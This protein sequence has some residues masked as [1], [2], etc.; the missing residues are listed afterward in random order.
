MGSLR[1]FWLALAVTPLIA[2]GEVE[3]PPVCAECYKIDAGA[4]DG[5]LV[6]GGTPGFPTSGVGTVGQCDGFGSPMVQID[7]A[8]G[9]YCIDQ[10]EAT[11]G[12]YDT[13]RAVARNARLPA[14]CDGNA[15]D[16][17][18]SPVNVD[19]ARPVY[20]VSWCDAVGYCRYAGKRLCGSIERAPDAGLYDGHFDVTSAATGSEW[21][22]ACSNAG[23][24]I[25]P[26]GDVFVQSTCNAPTINPGTIA[27]PGQYADCH[28]LTA[29]FDQIYDMSGNIEEWEDNCETPAGAEPGPTDLCTLRGGEFLVL[30][31]WDNSTRCDLMIERAQRRANKDVAGI[32]CCKDL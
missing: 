13:F 11:V 29:P 5:G 32:R 26:Y 18:A 15:F 12:E 6:E 22:Y 2:C 4:N 31:D 28:G 27:N 21:F 16:N 30:L 3:K 19:P 23:T 10:Y 14:P 8:S 9:S 20:D 24:S 7:T 17:G 1:L 25:Y